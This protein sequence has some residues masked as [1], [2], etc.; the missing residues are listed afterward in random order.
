MGGGFP[1]LV[2]DFHQTRFQVLY[3]AGHAGHG[4][5]ELGDLCREHF[6]VSLGITR[7]EF[8]FL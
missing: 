8:E 5:I 1:H 7:G 4:L 6:D 3:P 2:V